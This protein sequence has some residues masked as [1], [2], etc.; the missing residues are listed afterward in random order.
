MNKC[1]G[2][3]YRE[4]YPIKQVTA[5]T[6]ICGETRCVTYWEIDFNNKKVTIYNRDFDLEREGFESELTC[7]PKAEIWN[8]DEA[9]SSP[10]I[11]KEYLNHIHDEPVVDVDVEFDRGSATAFENHFKL[12]E[13]NTFE[14]IE[15]YGNNFFNLQ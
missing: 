6:T 5:T 3:V 2:I 1:E 8:D 15:N 14:D 4:R 7:I 9:S 13:C 10:V 11:K 12:M